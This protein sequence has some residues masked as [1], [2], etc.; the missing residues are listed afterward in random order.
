[1]VPGRMNRLPINIDVCKWLL[2]V[3][4]APEVSG[5]CAPPFGATD[6]GRVRA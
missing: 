5:R 2:A 6:F 1:M 4:M 3:L